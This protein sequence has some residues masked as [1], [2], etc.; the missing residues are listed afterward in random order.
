M[1]KKLFLNDSGN[2]LPNIETKEINFIPLHKTTNHVVTFLIYDTVITKNECPMLSESVHYYIFVAN[3]KESEWNYD[4]L[5][6]T[7]DKSDDNL[8]NIYKEKLI[9]NICFIMNDTI[10]DIK[11]KYILFDS[12]KK[13]PNKVEKSFNNIEE[14][15]DDIEKYLCSTTILADRIREISASRRDLIKYRVSDNIEIKF[16]SDYTSI[17]YYRVRFFM[18]YNP[19]SIFSKY[20]FMSDEPLPGNF[21]TMVNRAKNI[22]QIINDIDK[23]INL[24][25]NDYDRFY[26]QMVSKI[27]YNDNKYSF[28]RYIIDN[29]RNII[30]EQKGNI[31]SEE[32][33]TNLVKQCTEIRDYYKKINENKSIKNLCNLYNM[34]YNLCTNYYIP[35][36]QDNSTSIYV[37]DTLSLL[38]QLFSYV[39]NYC[40]YLYR[41]VVI[42]KQ[43]RIIC[44]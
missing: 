23:I 29:D 19:I 26:L 17:P 34:L 28:W 20:E 11:R 5:F 30:R 4:K 14:I 2:V 13:S 35:I 16:N 24:Y 42:K 8:Q 22:E 39:D 15:F 44:E 36:I 10:L 18:G 7:E 31:P 21:Y 9:A 33:Y 1:F 3:I 6:C 25:G 37:G 43:I 41:D 38:K 32:N 40:R 12:G 27:N